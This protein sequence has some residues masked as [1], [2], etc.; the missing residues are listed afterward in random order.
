MRSKFWHCVHP[1]PSPLKENQKTQNQRL[2]RDHSTHPVPCGT[3]A[4]IKVK[5]SSDQ[6]FSEEMCHYLLGQQ[7]L[8]HLNLRI[9][10]ATVTP[11]ALSL[12]GALVKLSI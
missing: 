9:Y 6:C 11:R 3:V 5:V 1:L 8:G 4:D 7:L 2:E 12:S 10:N